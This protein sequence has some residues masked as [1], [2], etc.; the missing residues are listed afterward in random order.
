MPTRA[1]MLA[2]AYSRGLMAPDK[3]A[4]FEEAVRRGLV[5]AP[6]PTKARADAERRINSNPDQ[7]RAITKGVTLGFADELDA[8]SAGAETAVNNTLRKVTGRPGVGYGAKDAYTAVMAANRARDDRFAEEHPVQN[9]ALQ[10]AG[11]LATPGGAAAA[12]FVGKAASL[13]G[14][15]LRSGA[16]GA[17][18]GAVAGAG[19]AEDGARLKGAAAGGATG[20]AIGTVAPVVLKGGQALAKRSGAAAVEVYDRA[21]SAFGRE[22]AA[23][24]EKQV[25][26]AGG[27]AVDYVRHIARGVPEEA[28]AA[29]ATEQAGKPITAAEAIGRR[30]VTQLSALARRTGA[31]GDSL[32]PMLTSRKEATGSRLLGDLQEVTGLEPEAIHGDFV[33]LAGRLRSK[34]AP[35]YEEAYAAPPVQAEALDKLMTRPSMRKAMSRAAT[36]AAEEGRDPAALGFDFDAAGDVVHVRT[37]SNQT[38]DYVKRGLDDVLEGYRDG[39]TG[40]LRLDEGGRAVLNTL[41]E[42]RGVIAPQ[43][44]KYRAALDAGGEPLR[45][46]ESFRNAPKLMG[47]SVPVRLFRERYAGMTEAQQQAH[48]AGFVNN[49]LEQADGGRLNLRALRTPATMQKLATMMGP[50]RARLL[51]ARLTQEADLAKT[52]GRMMPGTGSPTMELQAAD[53]E[54]AATLDGLKGAARTFARGKPVQAALQ[55]VASPLV[56]AFRGA[57]TPIDQATRD[58]VGRLLQLSPSELNKVLKAAGVKPPSP[59]VGAGS[60]V[61]ANALARLG[62]AAAG[63]EVSGQR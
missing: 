18:Y 9:A 56:G 44:S 1:E 28:L 49:V 13:G 29:N 42:Y 55:A 22:A 10:I 36:I 43:G 26:R 39:T 53:A 45:L 16:V 35:L 14:A 61:T 27:R 46:E 5:S 8:L 20:A 41:N 50:A 3:K 47:N 23:P 24:T 37:P 4:A 7:L 51:A 60:L 48:L 38:L 57:Q 30:G 34:A 11:G 32:E 59:K 31:T 12:R 2:E 25:A 21:R 62:G 19:N 40:K 33:A 17:A 52:G 58:E 63:N 54:Q 6:A 15:A